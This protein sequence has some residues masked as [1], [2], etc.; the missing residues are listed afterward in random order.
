VIQLQDLLLLEHLSKTRQMTLYYFYELLQV[1]VDAYHATVI[2][3]ALARLNCEQIPPN[4][5][6]K[7]SL[8]FCWDA[9]VQAGL[10]HEP[11]AQPL[12]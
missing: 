12:A 1:G 4:P 11:I 9:V 2:S 3:Q 6:Q 8:L 10:I 5:L 7:Q